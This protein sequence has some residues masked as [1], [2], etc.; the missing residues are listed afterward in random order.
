MYNKKL[1]GFVF[2]KWSQMDLL[3]YN[4]ALC[5]SHVRYDDHFEKKIIATYVH[6]LQVA[7]QRPFGTCR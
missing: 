7:R 5:I 2:T 4:T 3:S 6:R 1:F